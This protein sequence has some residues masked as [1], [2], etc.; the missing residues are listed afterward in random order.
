[1]ASIPLFLSGCA[2]QPVP[3]EP[4]TAPH[5][6][7]SI[8]SGTPGVVVAAPH[9]TSD[10]RTGEIASAIA[11]RTGF[12]L[13]VAT[14]FSLEPGVSGR[15]AR[16]FQV[17]RPMEG[18]PGRPPSEEVAT[19]A[20]RDVYREYERRVREAAGGPLRFYV[21]IHGN[22]RPDTA[23]RIEIATV[24]IAKEWAVRLRALFELIRDAHLRAHPGV[25]RLDVVVEPADPIFYA[26]S[27]AKRDGILR[28]PERALHV[29]LPRAARREFSETYVPILAE[30]LTE[31]VALTRR[32]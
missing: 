30:F 10:P 11:E 22:G 1:M 20:A 18:I 19:Q 9:A 24:G 31:A 3:V 28:L 26:A 32:P 2:L 5:G 17:N 4:E 25:A 7:I 6:H 8:R 13:V 23:G 16:R 12:G 15:A 21:E 29:E 14:G 27:G